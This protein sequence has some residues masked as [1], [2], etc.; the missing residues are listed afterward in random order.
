M[1][2]VVADDLQDDEVSSLVEFMT[3]TSSGQIIQHKKILQVSGLTNKKIKFLLRKFL[4][5]RHLTGYGVLDTAGNFE[6]L[7]IKP[8]EKQTERHETLSPTMPY[9][10]P[11][12]LLPHPVKPSDMVEWQGQPPPKRLQ[13]NRK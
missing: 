8:E 1:T 2:R 10:E 4:Y 9:W 5:S 11:S 3:A 7:Q 6:I 13:G 12:S